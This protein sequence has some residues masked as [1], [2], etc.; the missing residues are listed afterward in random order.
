VIAKTSV[1]KNRV[2]DK[3]NVRT[4]VNRRSSYAAPWAPALAGLFA[5]SLGSLTV[6]FFGKDSREN[7]DEL[8]SSPGHIA[9]A[10]KRLSRR[11]PIP[12]VNALSAPPLNSVGDRARYSCSLHA[13]EEV[14]QTCYSGKARR[15]RSMLVARAN[16]VSSM[17]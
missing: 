6:H 3:K 2:I 16:G 1:T 12:Q 15:K 10:A 4:G 17:G 7:P 5:S 8:V 9:P 14:Q 11:A 13:S